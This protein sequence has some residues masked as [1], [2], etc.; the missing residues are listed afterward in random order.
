MILAKRNKLENI[1]SKKNKKI[2]YIKNKFYFIYL[3]FNIYIFAK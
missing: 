1:I 3:L 2:N